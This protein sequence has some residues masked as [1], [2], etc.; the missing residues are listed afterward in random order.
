MGVPMG[1]LRALVTA[2]EKTPI[3]IRQLQESKTVAKTSEEFMT[4]YHGTHKDNVESFKAKGILANEERTNKERGTV[5]ATPRP[6]V[7]FAYAVMGGETNYLKA[8]SKAKDVPDSDRALVVLKIPKKWY[9]ENKVR[10]STGSVP[11]ISFG[12]SI[13]P[14]YIQD[15]IVGDRQKV[16]SL[17]EG[18]KSESKTTVK[19]KLKSKSN[20][21]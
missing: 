20:G 3:E 5:F 8:G 13:P 2:A 21:T 1:T 18:N 4:L 7:G 15:V 17:M 6:D 11:E 10:E 14:E 9:D 19:V 12:K 16:Y